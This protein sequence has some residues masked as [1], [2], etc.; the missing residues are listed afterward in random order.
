[1]CD[2]MRLPKGEVVLPLG[3]SLY[4]LWLV[5]SRHSSSGGF[6]FAPAFRGRSRLLQPSSATVRNGQHRC[7]W[8]ARRRVLWSAILPRDRPI[9]R[10]PSI[11]PPFRCSSYGW[12]S[13]PTLFI[14][15]YMS[16]GFVKKCLFFKDFLKVHSQK[17]RLD[18]NIFWIWKKWFKSLVNQWKRRIIRSRKN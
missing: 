9:R 10:T 13:S 5:L 12:A 2:R 8:Q 4:A 3:R 1:M 11:V 16:R 18:C 6:S 14:L 15:Q 7:R 17:T